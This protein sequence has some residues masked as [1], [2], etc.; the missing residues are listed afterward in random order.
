MTLSKNIII[1]VLIAATVI[2][3]TKKSFSWSL[4]EISKNES[5]NDYELNDF[6]PEKDIAFLPPLKDKS[7]FE[8]I[9]DLSICRRKDVRKYIFLYLTQGRKYLKKSIERSKIYLDIIEEIFEKYNDIPRDIS[10]LPLLESAFNPYAVSR[11]KAVGLWQF[12]KNT[13][14]SLG[15]KTDRWIDERRDIEKSTIAAIK[16]LKSLYRIFNSWEL[17]LAAYNGGASR[18]KKA[19]IKTGTDNLRV[20]QKSGAL[21]KE[22]R[23]Y[24][25]RFIALLIIYKNQELFDIKD[26]VDDPPVLKTENIVI[27]Y[28]V[29]IRNISKI[30][31]VPIKILRRYNPGLKKN[32]TPPYYR[33]FAFRIPTDAKDILISNKAKLYKFSFKKLKKHIVKEG[34]CI[35]KIAKLY[36]TKMR[37]I[38]VINDIKNPHLIRPGLKLYI[39]I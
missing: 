27:N 12:I 19:M 13:S 14:R 5:S 9:E 21:N 29:D 34:E 24:V 2:T 32:I 11:S 31:G 23:E 8:S 17:A 35:S 30:S 16:H 7:L 36:N 4:F 38:I 6:D 37:R 22:T 33:N 18:V 3:F 28:P 39:P 26:K 25:P 20:L 10:L 1:S 15:L